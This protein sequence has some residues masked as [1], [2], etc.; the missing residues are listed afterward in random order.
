MILCVILL[1]CLNC[2]IT[3][4]YMY[5]YANN[6]DILSLIWYY[7]L[8][9]CHIHIQYK[10]GNFSYF[11]YFLS[12]FVDAPVRKSNPTYLSLIYNVLRL[13]RDWSNLIHVAN[14]SVHIYICL[15]NLGC[16]Y[17]ELSHVKKQFG[18][19]IL[20]IGNKP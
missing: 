12:C 17:S 6:I 14:I 3:Y 9:F 10:H 19:I 2:Q 7:T 18:I 20:N 15:R 16:E 1:W 11:N 5:L 13:I 4:L 8:S